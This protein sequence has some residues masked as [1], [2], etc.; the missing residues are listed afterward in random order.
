MLGFIWFRV[1]SL[2]F[3]LRVWGV[4]MVQGLRFWDWGLGFW[5][6]IILYGLGFKVLGFGKAGFM[7]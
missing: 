3:G 1:E 6:F 5:G 7:L 4:Y 2:G